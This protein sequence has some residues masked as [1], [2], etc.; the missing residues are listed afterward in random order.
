MH[1]RGSETVS[2]GMA[3]RLHDAG[4]RKLEAAGVRTSNANTLAVRRNQHPATAGCFPLWDTVGDVPLG[5]YRLDVWQEA[6]RLDSL[7]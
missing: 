2:S 5:L 6:T 4:T 3:A 1:L 7:Q